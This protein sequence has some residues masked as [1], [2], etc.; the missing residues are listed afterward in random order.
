M[1]NS[2]F[3][4]NLGQDAANTD[5]LKA[6]PSDVLKLPRVPMHPTPARPLSL[7]R[8]QPRRQDNRVS[9]NVGASRPPEPGRSPFRKRSSMATLHIDP[10][11]P[12]ITPAQS[13]TGWRR[14][15]FIEL[16]GDGAARIF[17]R[18]VEQSS[19][20]ATELQ[21][22]IL[23]H[24]LDPRFH[25]LPGCVE[26]MRPELERLA[27]MARRTLPDKENLFAPVEYDRATWERVQHG[28][29]RWARR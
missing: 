2:A 22:A 11:L 1:E 10:N 15:F 7:P 20:K 26:A 14:E 21:R 8:M 5:M 19:F 25:D 9:I 29:E 13:L 23:F 6:R 4:D 27:D 16:L 17:V 24:R 18:T 28:V 12:D 3:G